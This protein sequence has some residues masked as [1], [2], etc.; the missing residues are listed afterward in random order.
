MLTKLISALNTGSLTLL[1]ILNGDSSKDIKFYSFLKRRRCNHLKM[2]HAEV[3]RWGSRL[4]VWKCKF[5]YASFWTPKLFSRFKTQTVNPLFH[6][7]E[8]QHKTRAAFVVHQASK[9]RYK[10]PGQNSPKGELWNFSYIISAHVIS[11]QTSGKLS[12]L[13]VTHSH[14]SLDYYF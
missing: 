8:F 7:K 11:V 5:A 6:N 13:S 12:L 4:M 9:I 2:Q 1:R 10:K 3:W 14:L